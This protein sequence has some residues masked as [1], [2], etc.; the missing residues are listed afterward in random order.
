M[1]VLGAE[2]CVFTCVSCSGLPRGHSGGGG[3]GVE[4]CPWNRLGGRRLTSLRKSLQASLR[5]TR[6]I[7]LC[8]WNSRTHTIKTRSSYG[9][10][11]NAL[12]SRNI[13]I[14]WCRR[15]IPAG[16]IYV[17]VCAKCVFECKAVTFLLSLTST[18]C[19]RHTSRL[20]LV[21]FRVT[22]SK[23]QN[24]VY[25]QEGWHVQGVGFAVCIN[26]VRELRL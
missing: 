17:R 18:A 7:Y 9:A 15:H 2:W 6:V 22:D 13:F 12:R 16:E 1:C 19:L 14:L 24:Q 26:V 11:W 21:S 8:P 3:A 10:F 20:R 25:Y 5:G 23:K 4:G